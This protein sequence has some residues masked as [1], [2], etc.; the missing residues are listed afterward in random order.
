MLKLIFAGM[1]NEEHRVKQIFF[2]LKCEDS[3]HLPVSTGLPNKKE[4]FHSILFVK[5]P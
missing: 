3:Y 1:H 2:P 4:T 5:P